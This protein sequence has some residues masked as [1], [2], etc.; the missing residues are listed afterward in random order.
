MSL[1]ARKGLLIFGGALAAALMIVAALMVVTARPALTAT[2]QDRVRAV[3]EG[4][5]GS[6]NRSDFDAFASHVCADMLRADA[7]EAGWYQ[8]RQ[9]D[10]P[11]R[12]TVNSV[13]VMGDDAVANVRFVAANHA[14]AKTLDIDFLREGAEW[15]ACR[16]QTGQSV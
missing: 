12:I 5:N 15:K 9:T 1:G 2:D 14:D 4:M 13:D 3:L 16:Y 11:T 7:Y 8:S 6:Y 10:G